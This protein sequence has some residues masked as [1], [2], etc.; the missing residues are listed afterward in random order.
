M[1]KLLFLPLLLLL[2]SSLFAKE[3]FLEGYYINDDN[4][5]IAGFIQKEVFI[6]NPTQFYYKSSKTAQK[7]L[8]T[9]ITV[10]EFGIGE[11]IR[12]QRFKVKMDESINKVTKEKWSKNP[13]LIEKDVFLKV[14]IDAKASLFYYEKDRAKKF[15]YTIDGGE[16]EQLIYSMYR[17]QTDVLRK[18]NQ[19]QQQLWNKLKCSA[20]TP[21]DLS[22]LKYLKSKLVKLF[23]SYNENCGGGEMTLYKGQIKNK[24]I[25][26]T[27]KPRLTTS[28]FE[29]VVKAKNTGSQTIDLPTK[30]SL[31]IGVELECMPRF[32]GQRF[33]IF[34]ELVYRSYQA[35]ITTNTDYIYYDV[36]DLPIFES[37]EATIEVKYQG[38]EIPLGIRY[39]FISREKFKLFATAAYGFDIPVEQTRT[40]IST[41]ETPQLR[42]NR[43]FRPRRTNY[44]GLGATF[45]NRYS[46]EFR[47]RR[48]ESLSMR[49]ER[50]FGSGS[51]RH[52]FHTSEFIFGYRI[53]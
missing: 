12:Y 47:Y 35:E 50:I 17:Y 36:N 49:G 53:F 43:F 23:K 21:K 34:A 44:L 20:W 18:N 3:K 30:S 13:D 39:R 41:S 15:F 51:W 14:I 29:T 31:Q 4:E 25:N 26:V 1:K 8:M 52:S 10:K 6:D 40:I 42:R 28:S 48:K 32:H 22:Q 38:L 24:A 19:Y 11:E 37:A 2:S 7:E 5:R 16:P 45:L 9:L 27:L 46:V 33:S